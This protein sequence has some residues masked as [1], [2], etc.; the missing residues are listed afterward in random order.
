M[1]ADKRKYDIEIL[2]F[3]HDLQVDTVRQVEGVDTQRWAKQ[4]EAQAQEIRA[5]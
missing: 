1:I 5:R 2:D 4:M 3:T